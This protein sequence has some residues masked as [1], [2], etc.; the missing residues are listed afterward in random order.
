MEKKQV[1]TQLYMSTETRR[2]LR[3]I[4]GNRDMTVNNLIRDLVQKQL[5]EEGE[6]IDMYDGVEERGGYR[7]RKDDKE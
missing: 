7:P 4:A 5:K 1:S 3:Q 2:R 6:E